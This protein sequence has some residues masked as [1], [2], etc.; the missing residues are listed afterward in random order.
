M[1]WRLHNSERPTDYPIVYDSDDKKFR[2]ESNRFNRPQ[3]TTDGQPIKI[4]DS[5]KNLTSVDGRPGRRIITINEEFPGPVIRVRHG[6]MVKITIY[7]DMP[8]QVNNRFFKLTPRCWAVGEGS[9]RP[10]L[11][12]P[13]IAQ[14]IAGLKC[15][16][17]CSLKKILNNFFL[18]FRAARSRKLF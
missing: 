4:E 2:P 13:L 18:I 7:N 15:T 16:Q 1:T 17:F 6:S 3:P 11:L 5:F 12:A 10:P 9:A 14:S 8:Y